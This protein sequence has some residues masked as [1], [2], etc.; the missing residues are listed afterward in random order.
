MLVCDFGRPRRLGYRDRGDG[1]VT[2]CVVCSG[3]GYALGIGN[4]VGD[5]GPRRVVD[6]KRVCVWAEAGVIVGPSQRDA[7]ERPGIGS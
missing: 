5:R 7:V 3:R 2:N 1:P 4:V 6:D